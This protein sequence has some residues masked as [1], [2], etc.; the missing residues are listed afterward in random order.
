[1]RKVIRL[2]LLAWIGL[3][4]LGLEARAQSTVS[5]PGGVATGGGIHGSTINIGISD[6]VLEGLVRDRTKPLQDLAD[7]QKDTIDLLKDKLQ[8]NERQIRAAL[9]AAGEADV[10]PER[11]GE[12]LVEIAL[13]AGSRAGRGRPR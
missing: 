7:T 10:A 8:L 3:S 2:A 9:N 13:P 5:A 4:S 6:K 11:I 1:M 12:K